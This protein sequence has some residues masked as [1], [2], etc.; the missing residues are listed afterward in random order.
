MCLMMIFPK[1]IRQKQRA[2]WLSLVILR[3]C[4]IPRKKKIQVLGDLS[5]SSACLKEKKARTRQGA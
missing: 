3:M 4:Y 5:F 1:C 2:K